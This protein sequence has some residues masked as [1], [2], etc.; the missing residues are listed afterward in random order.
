MIAE[1]QASSE[2]ILDIIV[3]PYNREVFSTCGKNRIQIWR[4]KNRNMFV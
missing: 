1:V 3:N 4:L 2:P